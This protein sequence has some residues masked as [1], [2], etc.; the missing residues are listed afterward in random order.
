MG[1]SYATA[2]LGG[3]DTSSTVIGPLCHKDLY[4]VSGRV[5]ESPK[6]KSLEI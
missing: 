2:A 5:P 3:L 4:C 6:I 1:S